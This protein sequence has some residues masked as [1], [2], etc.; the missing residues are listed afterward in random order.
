MYAI[1]LKQAQY[2]TYVLHDQT[3]DARLEIV[4]ERGGLVT[5]WQFQGRDILYFDAERFADASKSVRGG[6]PILFP[7]CGNLPDNTY[8]LD[9][10]DYKLKQHGFARDLPWEVSDRGTT[11]DAHLTLTLSSNNETLQVY[12]FEFQVAFTY[13]LQGN[14]LTLE[15]HVTNGSDRPMPFSLGLHPYFLTTDK[16]QLQFEIPSQHYQDQDS[17]EV[18][19]LE[20]EF[21]WTAEE[22][23]I[24]FFDLDRQSAVVTNPEQ[25]I[26]LTLEWSEAYSILVFWTVKGKDYY[27]LEPWSGPRNALNTGTHLITVPPH[28]TQSLQVKL[29]AELL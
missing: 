13:R 3:T 29:T 7:I 27:C 26:R 1:A 2:L 8:T 24:A 22:I 5:H 9:S 18:H 11:E 21:D 25:E 12:P 23:D 17:Q 20:G 4:P 16:S 6:I 14:T 28:E 19:T 15:Q 10:Q